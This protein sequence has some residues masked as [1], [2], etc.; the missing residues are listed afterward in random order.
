MPRRIP[1]YPDAYAGW[2]YVASIGSLISLMSVAIL[3]WV[4]YSMCYH[5]ENKP[6]LQNNVWQT[7]TYYS[8][9]YNFFANYFNSSDKSNSNEEKLLLKSKTNNS[10]LE[11]SLMTPAEYH[12]FTQAPIMGDFGAFLSLIGEFFN[13]I[14]NF[15]YMIMCSA[16]P[17]SFPPLPGINPMSFVVL[18]AYLMHIY[19]LGAIYT[20]AV[21]FVFCLFK[22]IS[23]LILPYFPKFTVKY[24]FYFDKPAKKAWTPFI[25]LQKT[26]KNY[27]SILWGYQDMRRVKIIPYFLHMVTRFIY[28]IIY[29]ALLLLFISHGV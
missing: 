12:S 29:Y 4:F 3:I 24:L 7:E 14:Y 8:L 17:G 5:N 27:G 19:I 18:V 6:N 26:H 25:S 1:D 21:N 22:F 2:N 11:F 13:S 23:Y 16:F 15:Y 20:N 10:S 9:A 28:I